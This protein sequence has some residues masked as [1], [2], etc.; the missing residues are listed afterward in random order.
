MLRR[1]KLLTLAGLR[2][3]GAFRMVRDS[4]WR[5]ERLLILCYHG[6]AQVDEHLWRPGLFMP[7]ELLEQRLQTLQRED[8][9]VIGLS[10]GLQRLQ[11]GE[12]SPR[13]VVITFDDGG[14]DFF[15]VA[16]PLLKKY[17][18]PATV[19]QTTYYSD[20]QAPIF[21]LV[22]SYLLWQRRGQVLDKG[23]ELGFEPLM[24]LRTEQSRHNLVRKL[25]DRSEAENLTGPRKNQIAAELGKILDVDYDALCKKRILHLMTHDEVAQ[26]ALEGIDIQLHTHRHRTPE[27]EKLFRLEIQDNRR[28]LPAAAKAAKHFCYP[29]GVYRKQFLGWLREEN[30]ISATTCDVALATRQSDPLL[31]PRFVDTTKR[32]NV[33]FESWLTGIG[34]LLAFRR[35]ATQQYS[36]EGD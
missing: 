35:A 24:D 12:L 7:P 4:Q 21:N 25:M 19:Y 18:F 22:C 1:I 11:A 2:A 14:F 6:I 31:L 36:P 23:R 10:E 32:T 16:H 15:K 17:G 5:R 26:L 27:D 30:V 28:S 13:S 3:G 34:D 8:Y 20:Y 9:S 29:A 33:E